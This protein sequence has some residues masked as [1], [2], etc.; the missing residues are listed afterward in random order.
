MNELECKIDFKSL[1]E[2]MELRKFQSD[3]LYLINREARNNR[4]LIV[5]QFDSVVEMAEN[6]TETYEI[7]K[8]A[9]LDDILNQLW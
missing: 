2:V 6:K 4:V 1:E 7:F 3:D 8:D 9:D 5:E